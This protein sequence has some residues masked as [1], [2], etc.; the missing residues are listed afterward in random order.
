MAYV[1]HVTDILPAVTSFIGN[2]IQ[3]HLHVAQMFM[4]RCSDIILHDTNP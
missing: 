3:N 4:C 1:D 2:N